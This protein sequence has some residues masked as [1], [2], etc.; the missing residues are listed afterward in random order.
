MVES[1]RKRLSRS[2]A[3]QGS[4]V[5]Q[6]TKELNLVQQRSQQLYEAVEKGLLPMDSTLT[7]RAS[8]L[9]AQRQALLTE[10][11]GLRRL[12]QMPVE[13]LGEKQV[14]AFTTAL[15]ERF[16]EKDRMFSK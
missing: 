15:R 6:L 14:R 11:A 8:K 9:Q 10:I 4:K 7:E 16:M 13:A 12:K 2:Q 5:K 3:S 1:L